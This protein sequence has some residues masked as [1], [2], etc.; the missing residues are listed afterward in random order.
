MRVSCGTESEILVSRRKFGWAL[1]A[2]A[3]AG[4]APALARDDEWPN[5]FISPMGKPYRAVK[6]APY[7]VVD[8]FKQA[9]KDGDGKLDHAEFMA[10]AAAFFAQLDI[11]KDGVLDSYEVAIYEHNIAPEVLGF[12]VKVGDLRG[13]RAAPGHDGARLWRAQMTDPNG[14]P[15][16]T[17]NVGNDQT[18]TTTRPNDPTPRWAPRRSACMR[19]PRADHRRRTRS[20]ST[21]SFWKV[22]FMKLADR[23]FSALDTVASRLSDP[24]QIAQDLCA[25]NP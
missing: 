15:L 24:R 18:T 14:Y 10:D 3:M 17:P 8:W 20:T 4:A 21:A 16:P 12:T 19:N 22:N 13:S 11:N 23:R 6:T 5:V 25:E 7:P 2:L 1:G 9:D